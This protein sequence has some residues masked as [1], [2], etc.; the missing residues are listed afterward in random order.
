MKCP[1]A[2]WQ[3]AYWHTVCL[4]SRSL[5]PLGH[6]AA[7]GRHLW[8][9]GAVQPPARQ[10]GGFM[11]NK[12]WL[13]ETPLRLLGE[14]VVGAG[15]PGYITGGIGINHNGELANAIALIDQ[16]ADAGCD[17]VKFQK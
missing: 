11:S 12:S 9:S 17:A 14:H 5:R 3:T 2:Y 15:H 4:R 10:R 6:Y 13:P 7:Y 16:A 1:R 8:N